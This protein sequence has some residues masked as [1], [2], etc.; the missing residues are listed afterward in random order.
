M[1]KCYL[2]IL[3]IMSFIPEIFLI[4]FNILIF[5]FFITFQYSFIMKFNINSN[6]IIYLFSILILNSM[7]LLGTEIS[8]DFN[9]LNNAFIKNNFSYIIE[10][11]FLFIFFI[12]CI[13]VYKYN[14]INNINNFEFL[15]ITLNSLIICLLLINISNFFTLFILLEML[16]IA[17]YVLAAF[18]KRFLYSIEAGLKYFI[19]GSFS[20]SLILLGIVILYSFT[21]FFSFEDLFMLFLYNSFFLEKFYFIGIMSAFILIL[22]GFLFKLYSAP[23]HFWILDIYQGSPLS[24]LLFF[25]TI[26]IF[27]IVNIFSK[28]YFFIAIDFFFIFY[29]IYI[30]FASACIIFGILGAVLQRKIRKLLAY[31]TITFIGY[32]L[33]SFIALDFFAIEYS[34]HYFMIYL[35]NLIAIFIFLLNII[36]SKSNLIFDKLTDFSCLHKT[37]SLLSIYSTIYLFAASGMPPFW[38]FIGKIGLYTSLVSENNILY[39]ILLLILTIIGFFYYIR[40]IK[41]IFFST[42]SKWY[43]YNTLNYPTA[44]VLTFIIFFNL[45]VLL[46]DNTLVSSV[47]FYSFSFL[48]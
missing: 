38:G 29:Y 25:S 47:S 35:I 41:I 19:L 39:V 15:F 32:Y 13:S 14:N 44:L 4:F 48:F 12:Y 20:S 16:S 43:F 34:L 45:F 6:Y 1:L 9:L 18:N 26:Y 42:N 22:V 21:G 3:K 7:Y 10:F 24:S 5:I 27:T 2:A 11:F 37:N 28:L 46:I 30:F 33:S 8:I 17:L 40:V 31:S 23:F 36:Y